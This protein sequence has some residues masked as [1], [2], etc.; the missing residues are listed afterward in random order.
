M[1]RWTEAET[2][3]ELGAKE[4]EARRVRARG[5]LKQVCGAS[6]LGDKR[7]LQQSHSQGGRDA[8][9]PSPK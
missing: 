1:G 7:R 5:H 8:S 4:V 6:P 3:W 9:P 2:G